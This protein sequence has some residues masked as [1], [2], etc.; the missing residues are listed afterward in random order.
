MQRAATTSQKL[1]F[2]EIVQTNKTGQPLLS[3]DAIRWQNLIA[4]FVTWAITP[5]GGPECAGLCLP[6]GATLRIWDTVCFSTIIGHAY[7]YQPSAVK[8]FTG[9]KKWRFSVA[10][11]GARDPLHPK[12]YQLPSLFSGQ[13]KSEKMFPRLPQND[14]NV[15]KNPETQISMNVSFVQYFPCESLELRDPSLELSTQGSIKK[16]P[17]NKPENKLEFQVSVP[18]N[19]SK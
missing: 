16:R 14:N 2:F 15:P 18:N 1:V 19:L 12:T 11:L 8:L 3:T 7:S 9:N 4:N 6:G 10:T 13:Q 5:R 17:G